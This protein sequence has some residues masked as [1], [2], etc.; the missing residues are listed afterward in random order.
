M[1]ICIGTCDAAQLYM[2]LHGYAIICDPIFF[3]CVVCER[4]RCAWNAVIY[5]LYMYMQ[6]GAAIYVFSP[7]TCVCAC[8]VRTTSCATT[9]VYVHVNVYVC[10]YVCLCV[11]VSVANASRRFS[12]PACVCACEV[13]SSRRAATRRYICRCLH[14]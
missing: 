13:R 11:C 10:T 8:E 3:F 2:D 4:V 14:E 9:Y 6:R 12:S 1:W 5:G 7:L